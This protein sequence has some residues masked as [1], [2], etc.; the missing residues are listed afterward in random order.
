[1][2]ALE[3]V[4]AGD[5]RSALREFHEM[6]G[7]LPTVLRV[8]PGGVW[9]VGVTSTRNRDDFGSFVGGGIFDIA[10]DADGNGGVFREGV[11]VVLL[12]C[13]GGVAHGA[14]RRQGV[15]GRF[16]AEGFGGKT[17][18][19]GVAAGGVRIPAGCEVEWR[20]CIL[21][22]RWASIIRR[23]CRNGWENCGRRIQWVREGD[24]R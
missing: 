21:R 18:G 6:E 16:G 9:H 24:E 22:T 7:I 17:G 2:S 19:S 20:Q 14:F 23:W 1:M 13:C 11:S 8:T 4:A 10:I 5:V 15:G 12:E 3:R